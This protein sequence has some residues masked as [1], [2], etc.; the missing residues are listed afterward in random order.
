MPT[1]ILSQRNSDDNQ[2]LWRAAV[3][4]GW[5]VERLS[6]WRVSE[7][8][9]HLQEP[10]LYAEALLAPHYAPELG[11]KLSELPLD[12]LPRLPREYRRREIRMMPLSGVCKIEF[13]CFIKPPND[14]SF[15]ASICQGPADLPV[16]YND[17]LP[18]LASDV[19]HWEKEFRCFVLDRCLET[20]SVY[21]RSGVLQ[22]ETDY[23]STQDEDRQV[24]QFVE[25]VL[26]DERVELPRA[27]VL[28]VGII[29]NC[30]WAVVEANAAWGSGI[31]GCDPE[32]VLKVLRHSAE[33]VSA[34]DT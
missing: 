18:V 34:G 11:L 33:H 2:R 1:L 14:K 19:V 31:Y 26:A 32:A 17:E 25:T 21:L 29:E 15:P 20:F 12:W 23:A 7:Q 9:K 22:N 13:P 5:D 30:G 8:L 6:G 28:D 3:R 16:N 4:L 27:V 10:V 24:R